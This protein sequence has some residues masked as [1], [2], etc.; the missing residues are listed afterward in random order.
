M[1]KYFYYGLLNYDFNE[2][3][4][5]YAGYDYLKDHSFTPL[6]YGLEA[7]T[8]GGGFRPHNNVVVKAQYIL[9]DLRD[10]PFLK[11]HEDH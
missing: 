10:N 4:F 5:G 1:T 11:F 2:K 8:F 3:F 7:Y 9:F 6:S